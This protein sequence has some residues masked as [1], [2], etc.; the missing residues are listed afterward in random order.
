MNM[1]ESVFL[2][3][4]QGLTEFLPISSSGHLVLF[5]NLLGI[6]EPQ[7]L[8]D[9]ALHLGTLMAIVIYFRQDLKQMVTEI[10]EVARMAPQ[11]SAGRPLATV[12]LWV[13]VG[14][15]PTGIIGLTFRAPL[16]RLF[17]SVTAVGAA[18]LATGA[19]VASARLPLASVRAQPALLTAVL[20]GVAQGI[21]IIPGISRSGATIVCGLM[22]GLDR[23]L[24]GRF[25]FFLAIPAIVGALLL[26]FDMEGLDRV[27][28]IALFA[29]FLSSVMVGLLALRFLM[30]MVVRGQLHYFA[31]Y[32]WGLGLLILFALR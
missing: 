6:E 27:G 20:V 28:L 7:L 9:S 5:Q 14:S 15:I 12:G 21:A 24:A 26:Q 18:L 32:C 23:D 4:I 22:C 19:I 30:G 2:G 13:L 25:S 1:G 31:P 29:G 16:E 11:S 10:W 8:L 17:G 3:I